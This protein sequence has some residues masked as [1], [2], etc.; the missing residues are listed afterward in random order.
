MRESGSQKLTEPLNGLWISELYPWFILS[1]HNSN[2]K[3]P[4]MYAIDI[5]SFRPDRISVYKEFHGVKMSSGGFDQDDKYPHQEKPSRVKRPRNNSA[6]RSLSPKAADRLALNIEWLVF[7]ARKKKAFNPKTKQPFTF[8]IN[9]ITLTLPCLQFHDDDTLKNKCLNQ[10]LTECRKICNLK[11]YVWRAECQKNGNLHIHLTA[12]VYLNAY[13]LRSIWNRCLSK[14]GYIDRYHAKFAGCSFPEYIRLVEP[15]HP[16]L[17]NFRKFKNKKYRAHL[18]R[19]KGTP[20]DVLRRRWDYGRQSNWRAPNTTDIHSVRKVRDLAAYL[21]KYVTKDS[22][23]VN[24]DGRYVL[25]ARRISGRLWGC[26]QSLSKLR[27]VRTV[28]TNT[29][30][31]LLNAM[32]DKFQG[33]D[34]HYDYASCFYVRARNYMQ[35]NFSYLLALFRDYARKCEYQP[36]RSSDCNYSFNST[37]SF[38]P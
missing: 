28:V 18:L 1:A 25:Q 35:L 36:A 13:L 32:V 34:F 6:G 9:F 22:T 30:H 2:F 12:D 21:R 26:S 3:F 8:K 29:I 14:L 4:P 31:N 20:V 33:C 17:V 15:N 5:A 10:F 16:F 38:S 7:L 37:I 19:K 27:T 23:A 11:N 24:S